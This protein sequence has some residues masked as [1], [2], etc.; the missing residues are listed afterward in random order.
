MEDKNNSLT[1][2]TQLKEIQDASKADETKR[3]IEK[4]WRKYQKWGALKGL[5]I[6]PSSSETLEKYLLFLKDENCKIATI[7]QAKWAINNIHKTRHL[8]EPANSKSGFFLKE[9][10]KILIRNFSDP[11]FYSLPNRSC[12]QNRDLLTDNRANESLKSVSSA[13]KN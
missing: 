4:H 1:Y 10:N 12:S 7:E 5:N 8:P 9:M 13:A 11:F 3:A 2:Q 6:L